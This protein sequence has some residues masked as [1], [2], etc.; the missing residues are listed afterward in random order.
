MAVAFVLR[1]PSS[2]WAEWIVPIRQ[3]ALAIGVAFLGAAVIAVSVSPSRRDLIR[4]GCSP[5]DR[6]L[7]AGILPLLAALAGIS[8]WQ[9]AMLL[10]W[11]DESRTLLEQL[12]A[13]ERDPLGLWTIPAAMVSAAPFIATLVVLLFIL[14]AI[15]V[16]SAGPPLAARVLRGCVLLQSGLVIGSSLALAPIQSLAAHVLAVAASGPD[17]G[18]LAAITEAVARQTFFATELI[19]RFQWILGGYVLAAF[20]TWYWQ[21][22]RA[23]PGDA[24]LYADVSPPVA[25]DP[26]V[27]VL[28]VPAVTATVSSSLSTVFGGS[29]YRVRLR[30]HWILAAFRVGY[31]DYAITPMSARASDARFS[32]SGKDGLFRS[33]PSGPCL[34]SVQPEGAPGG[35]ERHTS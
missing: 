9:F 18:I 13:G 7:P 19:S 5:S 34:L 27:G 11:W 31:L 24:R 10:A 8:A 16:A 20:A 14:T 35:S 15:A 25:V 6:A 33:E 29:A 30:T 12:T 17:A 1:L 22:L 3:T 26:G 32:F 4:S 2:D 21:A 28:T 23:A